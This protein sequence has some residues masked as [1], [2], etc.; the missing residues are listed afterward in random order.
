M[1]VEVYY[2]STTGN[3]ALFLTEIKRG[4]EK[5]GHEC[6]L[7]NIVR[8]KLKKIKQNADLYGFACPTFSYRE[9]TAMKKFLKGLK[10]LKNCSPAFIFTSME[11]DSGRLF[12]RM[13]KKLQKKGF[14]VVDYLELCAPLNYTPILTYNPG[15]IKKSDLQRAFQFGVEL[16]DRY[17]KVFVEKTEPQPEKSSKLMNRL[18]VLYASDS[19]IKRYTGKILVDKNKCVK[20]AKCAKLCPDE[21]IMLENFPVINR[22]RCTGCCACVN[23]CFEK[24]LDSKRTLGKFHY[25][26]QIKKDDKDC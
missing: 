18:K 15:K 26:C 13:N 2:L 14:I 21:A 22:N 4:L 20:C 23:N 1:N 16:E 19:I 25:T 24:A 6:K 3:T 8:N 7:K 11:A 17:R 5:K 9:P 12:N 10:K